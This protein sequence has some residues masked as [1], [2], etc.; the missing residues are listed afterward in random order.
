MIKKSQKKTYIL[1]GIAMGLI[2]GIYQLTLTEIIQSE[3]RGKPPGNLN[4]EKDSSSPQK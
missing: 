4:D 3:L 1:M 2:A